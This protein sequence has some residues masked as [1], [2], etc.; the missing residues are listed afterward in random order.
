MPAADLEVS[1]LL[2]AHLSVDAMAINNKVGHAASTIRAN[3]IQRRKLI[4]HSVSPNGL[5]EFI[6]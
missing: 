5:M 1:R 4:P 6:E 3:I 2:H